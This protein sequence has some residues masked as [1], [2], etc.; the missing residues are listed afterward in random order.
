[1]NLPNLDEVE[2]T[3]LKRL[4]RKLVGCS[5]AE[6]EQLVSDLCARVVVIPAVNANADSADDEIRI[7]DVP[8]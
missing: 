3:E 6:Q 5:E 4:L 7:I 8:K 2:S 1:M